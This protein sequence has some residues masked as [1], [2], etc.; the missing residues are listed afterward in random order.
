MRVEAH[1]CVAGQRRRV[2]RAVLQMPVAVDLQ[3]LGRVPVGALQLVLAQQHQRQIRVGGRHVQIGVGVGAGRLQDAQRLAQFQ[4][5]FMGAPGL[6][7]QHR[8]VVVQGGQTPVRGGERA[9]AIGLRHLVQ[10]FGLIVVARGPHAG[11]GVDQRGRPGFGALQ[12]HARGQ[13]DRALDDPLVVLV[14]ALRA[15]ESHRFVEHGEQA[16]VIAGVFRVDHRLLQI[17]AGFG[18]GLMGVVDRVESGEELIGVEVA[19]CRG[20]AVFLALPGFGAGT[21]VLRFGVRVLAG[22][23]AGAV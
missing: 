15:I 9:F 12:P 1:L 6:A 22:F 11:R 14:P 17:R 21:A 13:F 8:Q 3:S 4:L 10:G 7:V 19:G 18:G 2:V 16:G 5:G 23:G 20:V